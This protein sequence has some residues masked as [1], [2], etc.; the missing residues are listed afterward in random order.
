MTVMFY[1]HTACGRQ[2]WVVYFKTTLL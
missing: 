1:V 2:N